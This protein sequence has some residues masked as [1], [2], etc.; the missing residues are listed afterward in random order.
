MV[1]KGLMSRRRTAE[2]QDSDASA[3]EEERRRVKVRA[4]WR[5]GRMGPAC[6]RRENSRG[7]ILQTLSISC[8]HSSRGSR[9]LK[10]SICNIVYH[11]VWEEEEGVFQGGS[12]SEKLVMMPVCDKAIAFL[13]LRETQI[14]LWWN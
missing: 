9:K 5:K 12:G 4:E 6:M 2:R 3:G 1:N 10:N 11:S 7:F 8:S 13:L 14:I